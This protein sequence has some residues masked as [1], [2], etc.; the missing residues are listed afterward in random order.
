MRGQTSCLFQGGKIL[1]KFHGFV[2]LSLVFIITLTGCGSKSHSAAAPTP[3]PVRS[4]VNYDG[5]SAKGSGGTLTNMEILV[6]FNSAK[7]QPYQGGKVIGLKICY[8][9]YSGN[10]STLPFQVRLYGTGTTTQPGSLIYN[11]TK[12]FNKGWNEV[13]LSSPVTIT[14]T[15]EVWAGYEVDCHQWPISWDA[16]PQLP[17]INFCRS[18][19][20]FEPTNSNMNYNVRLIVEK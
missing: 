14:A 5:E 7:L 13:L 18:G 16:G 6:Y 9:D 3:T 1:E 8:F 20:S 19:A 15:T 11:E 17:N 2:L 10:P 12:T 4:I